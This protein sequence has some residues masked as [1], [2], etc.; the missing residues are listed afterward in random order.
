MRNGSI[1]IVE[2]SILLIDSD[3]AWAEQFE[4]ERNLIESVVGEFICGS[5]EHVGSTSVTGL[6]AKPV[7]DIMVGVKTL[8][9]S[10]PAIEILQ[11]LGYCYAP[12]K[13]EVMHW[14]CKP[15]PEFR[16]HH[17]HLVPYQS[18][19]WQDRIKFRDI[20]RTDKGIAEKYE[21]L[22]LSLAEKYKADRDEYTKAKWPFIKNVLSQS[23]T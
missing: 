21:A 20:L 3:P 14:F 22:K 10:K 5:I 19:L 8:D 12:Y 11:K 18:N 15:S 16:T 13:T 2:K 1:L 6:M 17:L 7:I 23:G 4:I 9:A